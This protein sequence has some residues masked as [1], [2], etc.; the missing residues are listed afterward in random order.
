[1]KTVIGIAISLLIA[2]PAAAAEYYPKFIQA[3]DGDTLTL[4]ID[5][6]RDHL[7][8]AGVDSPEIKGKCQAERD[9]ALR[10]RDFTRTWAMRSDLTLTT[11]KRER[12]KYGRLLGELTNEHGEFLSE[13]LIEAGLAVRWTGK[14]FQHW[15]D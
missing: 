13:K 7:R 10:A 6:R 11:G 9:L 14:R 4:E 3:Y 1:M 5:G 12:E 2:L 15:C 8:L